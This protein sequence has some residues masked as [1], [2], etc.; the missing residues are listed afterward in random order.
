[1]GSLREAE[2]LASLGLWEEAWQT[3]DELSTVDRIMPPA[4]RIRLDCCPHVNAW[5][6]GMEIAKLLRDG[7]PENRLAAAHFYLELARLYIE[8]DELAGAKKAVRD[9]VAA[10]PD[11]HLELLKDPVIA[12]LL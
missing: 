5:L 3:L 6:E 7:T 11:G 8:H 10:L 2:G 9:C 4:L 12:G 1:M